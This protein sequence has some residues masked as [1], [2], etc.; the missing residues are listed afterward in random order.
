MGRRAK[1]KQGPP[2]PYEA[3]VRREPAKNL[4]KRKAKP[5]D[6]EHSIAR[7]PKKSKDIQSTAKYS[8]S[9]PRKRDSKRRIPKPSSDEEASFDGWEDVED[10]D[11]SNTKRM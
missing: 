6:L 5:D 7:P 2:Q 9:E 10:G 1:N 11:D 8:R 4:G 3:N